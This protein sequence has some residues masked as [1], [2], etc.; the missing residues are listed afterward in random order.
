M[1]SC[2]HIPID[3]D[4]IKPL[5]ARV[6]KEILLGN[7]A[8]VSVCNAWNDK[9]FLQEWMTNITSNGQENMFQI[10]TSSRGRYPDCPIVRP[11]EELWSPNYICDV[12]DTLLEFL[13]KFGKYD[14][15]LAML[16]N[17]VIKA[18][19]MKEDEIWKK[20]TQHALDHTDCTIKADISVAKSVLNNL[21]E[22]G[23]AMDGTVALKN[24]LM[25][26]DLMF[27]FH[28]LEN[29]FICPNVIDESS[30]GVFHYLVLSYLKFEDFDKI[31]KMLVRLGADIN[32]CNNAGYSPLLLCMQYEMHEK[33]FIE[34]FDCLIRHGA[35]IN[36]KD[37]TGRSAL[38]MY[39]EKILAFNGLPEDFKIK[40][41]YLVSKGADVN[42]RI[43]ENEIGILHML[44]IS[45]VTLKVFKYIHKCMMQC[46]S[47]ANIKDAHGNSPLAYCMKERPG[48]FIDRCVYLIQNGTRLKEKYYEN[49]NFLLT[50]FKVYRNAKCMEILPQIS[51]YIDDYSVVDERGQNA[52]HYVFKKKPEDGCFELFN[53][54]TAA[55]V[56]FNRTDDN[57]VLPVMH[58]IKNCFE[59]PLLRRLIQESPI[60]YRDTSGKRLFPLS[61]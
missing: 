42:T 2:R 17:K 61:M 59:L 32:L 53:Y 37:L 46:D 18:Y 10:L 49:E 14:A 1:E 60:N 8:V 21:R 15:V 27:A 12:D 3:V 26:S 48:D 56:T 6:V 57:D 23:L 43:H 41:K 47:D 31:S 4:C 20:I 51:Y 40:L 36:M 16:E 22:T 55:G 50:V 35:N 28:L 29:T 45:N 38:Y 11:M 30:G 58:A 34:R 7:A 13:T 24:A 33:Q 9:L 5:A 25:I 54:L 39:V 19:F 52:M 44:V